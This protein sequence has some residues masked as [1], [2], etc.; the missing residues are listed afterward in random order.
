M[1][2]Q[3]ID[4]LQERIRELLQENLRLQLRITELEIQINTPNESESIH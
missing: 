2:A 4:M 1:S 3:L